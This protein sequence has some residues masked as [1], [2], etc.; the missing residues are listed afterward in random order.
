MFYRAEYIRL[1]KCWALFGAYI[2]VCIDVIYY[3]GTSP[4]IN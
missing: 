4:S 1:G 3:G 2:G